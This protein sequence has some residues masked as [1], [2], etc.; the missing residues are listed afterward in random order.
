MRRVA[1]SLA[2]L[3]VLLLFGCGDIKGPKGESGPAGPQGE[4]GPPGPVGPAGPQGAAGPEGPAGPQG[5]P[6]PQ[7]SIGAQGEPGETG[8]VGPKGETG[9]QGEP[10]TAGIRMLDPVGAGMTSSCDTGEVMIGVYCTGTYVTYP[11]QVGPGANEASCSAGAD[12][13]V[14]VVVACA[15]K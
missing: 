4:A 10:G 1:T 2:C 9:D 5:E 7:G 11:L 15:K 8:P 3:S 12:S 14:K 13:D 6:G